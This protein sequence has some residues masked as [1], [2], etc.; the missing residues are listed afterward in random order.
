MELVDPELRDA[1]PSSTSSLP[2]NAD[3]V[4]DAHGSIPTTTPGH[5]ESSVIQ[6]LCDSQPVVINA[7]RG[8]WEAEALLAK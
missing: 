4:K 6:P 2:A 5:I 1:L 3:S 7:K 8:I